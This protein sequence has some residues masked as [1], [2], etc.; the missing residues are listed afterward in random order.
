MLSRTPL[1]TS[2]MVFINLKRALKAL[3]CFK[4]RQENDKSG[5]LHRSD[6]PEGLFTN[7]RFTLCLH[8]DVL[9]ACVLQLRPSQKQPA[10]AGSLPTRHNPESHLGL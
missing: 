8:A 3:M 7:K 5:S 2:Y 4:C 9:G 1:L 6:E 10:G